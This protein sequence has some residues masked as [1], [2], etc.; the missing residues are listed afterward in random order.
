MSDS[1][2]VM[3]FPG[4]LDDVAMQTVLD[5]RSRYAQPAKRLASV[6]PYLDMRHYRRAQSSE[7]S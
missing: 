6:E 2:K 3:A 5:L 1:L 4:A 7:S